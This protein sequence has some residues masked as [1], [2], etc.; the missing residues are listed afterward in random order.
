[1]RSETFG[2]L[3]S[4]LDRNARRLHD[5]NQRSENMVRRLGP[6]ER[7]RRGVPIV[8]SSSVHGDVGQEIDKLVRQR[9]IVKSLGCLAGGKLAAV[10]DS[11]QIAA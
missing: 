6:G 3:T 2:G 10:R 11:F 8:E 7:V 1:M 5:S 9:Y 4:D